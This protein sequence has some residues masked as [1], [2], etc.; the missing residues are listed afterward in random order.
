MLF[1]K[2]GGTALDIRDV[3]ASYSS[4]VRYSCSILLLGRQLL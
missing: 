2:K 4:I 3:A 1:E